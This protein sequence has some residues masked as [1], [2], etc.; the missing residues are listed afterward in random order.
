[1]ASEP[2]PVPDPAAPARE[3]IFQVIDARLAPGVA[4]YERQPSSDP[5]KF[6]A[7]H[8]FDNGER[9]VGSESGAT[10]R[11]TLTITVEGYVEG[12]S[13]AGA[14]AA[15]NALHASTVALMMTEPPLGGLVETI[16]EARDLRVD[17]AELANKRRLGFSQDFEVT[18]STVRGDPGKFA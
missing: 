16:E 8:V 17:V 11:K 9:P 1:M 6:P 18:F 15:L 3:Q 10:T 4:S 7:R 5:A 14:H 13:G 12:H 2:V